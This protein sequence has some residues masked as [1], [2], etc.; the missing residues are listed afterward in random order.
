[1]IWH[2]HYDLTNRMEFRKSRSD[3]SRYLTLEIAMESAAQAACCWAQTI[4]K[5]KSETRDIVEIATEMLCARCVAIPEM[6]LWLVRRGSCLRKLVT[7]AS[8]SCQQQQDPASVFL[9]GLA[10]QSF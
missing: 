2:D 8:A 4:A 9:A 6:P 3:K 1:M 10:F 5:S 7:S